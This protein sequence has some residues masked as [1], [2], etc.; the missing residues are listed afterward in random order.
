MKYKRLARSRRGLGKWHTLWLGEDHL[1]AVESTGYSE[2]YTR[3][4]LKEIQAI[5]TRRSAWGVVLNVIAGTFVAISLIAVIGSYENGPSPGNVTA[6]IFGGFFLL[7]LLWN[8]MSGPTCRCH[9][10]TAVGVDEL[11]A[12]DRLWNV[13][14]VMKMLRPLIGRLQGEITREEIT[15]LA[16]KAAAA[17]VAAS[18]PAA[19]ATKRTAVPPVTE[20]ATSTYRGGMHLAAFLCLI[21]NAGLALLRSLH[22]S[23]VLVYLSCF[24]GFSFLLLAVIAM[25]RQRGSLVASLARWLTWAGVT[26]MM[27]GSVIGYFFMIFLSIDKFKRGVTTQ[28]QI[29]DLY[30]A[31]QPAE[32]PPYAYFLIA[33]AVIAAV[34]GT[35]GLIALERKRRVAER[36]RP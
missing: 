5:I 17:P 14:K 20:K 31:I 32:H 7:L 1:L 36:R 21:A 30:A 11:P 34:I 24:A 27:A 33:Y 28:G 16:G 3:Y 12:L 35:A 6:G 18:P 19:P 13:K 10:R 9:V 29:L 26:T 25:I 4:Y 2:E 8:L 22:N 15:I 23:K